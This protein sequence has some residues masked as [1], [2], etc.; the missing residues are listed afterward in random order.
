[1]AVASGVLGGIG[2][3]GQGQAS[4]SAAEGANRAAQENIAFLSRAGQA[5]AEDIATGARLGVEASQGILGA[6]DPIQGFADVGTQGFT[7]ARESILSGRTGSPLTDVISSAGVRA[8]ER[9]GPLSG[10]VRRDLIRRSRL[11][12]EQA[13]PGF[14]QALLGFGQEV[15]VGGQADISGLRLRQADVA[16]DILRQAATQEASALIGQA[17]NI[18]QQIETGQTARALGQASTRRT[19]GQGAE[20]IANLA[21]RSGA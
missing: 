11:T 20:L 5:G 13:T 9:F 1:M 6:I 10:P 21:G 16:G 3:L 15:G 4:R 17:P 14:N 8:A 2:I 7:T 12:A 18:A 19:V